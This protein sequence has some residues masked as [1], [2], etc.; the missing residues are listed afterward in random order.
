MNEKK[1]K[2]EKNN[3]AFGI[4]GLTTEEVKQKI[5][6]KQNNAIIHNINKTFLGIILSNIF[7]FFNLL[8]FI[9]ICIII[10]IGR[11]EQLFFLVING[12]NLSINIFQEIKAKITLDKISIL[13]LNKTKVIRNFNIIE[14]P[15]DNIVMNDILFLELGSQITAD[16]KIKKGILEVDE[17]F[18]TGESKPIF[19]KEGDILYSGSY[20]VSGNACAEVFC[21]G[22]EM[23]I[24]KLTKEAKKYKK[25]ETPLLRSSYLLVCLIC[26]LSIPTILTLCLFPE[27]IK[28]DDHE[29]VLKICGC[30]IAMIPSGL[31]LLTS[32][33][34]FIGFIKL[35]KQNAYVKDLFGMEM[36]SQI[37]VLCLDKT[38]TITTGEMIVKRVLKYP[39]FNLVSDNVIATIINAF[40]N[41]NPTQKALYRKFCNSK[42]FNDLNENS[43]KILNIQPF[44]S[45]KKYSAVEIDKKGTFILGAPEFILKQQFT[46]IQKVFRQQTELGLRVLILVQTDDSLENI[47]DDT[48]YKIIC[49]ISLEDQIKENT[50]ETINYFM[51]NGIN[52]KII[53][54]DNTDTINCI[55][56]KLKIIKSSKESISLVNIDDEVLKKNSSKYNVFGRATPKQKKTIIQ[57]LRKQNYNVAMI[58]DGVNDI[59]AFKESNVS[60]AM[61]SGNEASKNAANLILLDSQFSSLPKVVAEGR[62]VVNNLKK[63]SVLFLTKTI[64]SFLL[65]FSCIFFNLYY[66]LRGGDNG[67]NIKFP[68]NPLQ[69]NLIDI[70]FIGIPAFFLTLEM[71]NKKISKSFFK[72]VLPKTFFY[73]SLIF[74]F[75]VFLLCAYPT[76][77]EVKISNLVHLFSAFIFFVLLVDICIPFNKWKKILIISVLSGFIIAVVCK[78]TLGI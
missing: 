55:A 40:P 22:S 5:Q 73:S 13:Q 38:G 56:Q 15:I 6:N 75:Y 50:L 41:N 45:I 37:D 64:L 54:G 78:T 35:A 16:S 32:T 29:S 69:F 14:I 53:S 43:Y 49:L 67:K 71:N 72:S 3:L 24:S 62:R 21:V 70:F 1:I 27:R 47:N 28:F 19:K 4:K 31:F 52:V 25:I 77:N 9:V 42:V 63:I 17:S 68:L 7:T 51:Q 11:F 23:Y 44:S 65:A 26:C 66:F 48:N 36:L 59:L 12:I 8:L 76:Y 61:S 60:I 34:L 57:S 58:G 20:V 30:I 18:L 39:N 10:Y 2:L 74:L 46:Q 33:T